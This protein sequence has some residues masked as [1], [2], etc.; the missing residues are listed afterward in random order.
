MSYTELSNF[1]TEHIEVLLTRT[2]IDLIKK[3]KKKTILLFTLVEITIT[4]LFCE[5]TLYGKSMILS[6][7]INF[8]QLNE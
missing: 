5:N 6:K 3:N 2:D 7:K 4:Q 8:I 1:V